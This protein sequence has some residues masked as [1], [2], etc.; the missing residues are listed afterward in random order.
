MECI[1]HDPSC[2]YHA[3]MSDNCQMDEVLKTGSHFGPGK[4]GKFRMN[5]EL[6]IKEMI[7]CTTIKDPVR[8]RKQMLRE[9]GIEAPIEKIKEAM[10]EILKSN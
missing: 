1:K 5:V 4:C 10:K 6:A 9:F 8:I 3:C 2:P 7:S